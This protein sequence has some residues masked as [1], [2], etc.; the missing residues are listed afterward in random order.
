VSAPAGQRLARAYAWVVVAL[1]WPIIAGWLAALVAAVIFLP[2][3]GGPG[4]APLSDIVPSDAAAVRAQERALD[5]FGSTIAT[6]SL[7]VERDPA[8]LA[9]EDVEAQ[10]QAA[11]EQREPGLRAAVPVLNAPAPGVRWRERD[12]TLVTYLFISPDQNLLEREQT[13]Q[14]YLSGLPPGA[15]RGITGAGPARLAQWREIEDALPWTEA[16]TILTI[17]VIVAAYFRSAGA[18]L[19]TLATA[20]LAYVVAIRALAWIGERAGFTAPAEVEP[21]LVV[22]LIGLVTDYTIFFMAETRRRLRQGDSRLE[23]A[24][25]ATARVAPLVFA[26]GVLV[27]A[28]A[29]ALLAGEMRFFRVFG[30]GL[31]VAAVV[32]TLVCVTLVP[33][34]MGAL[35]PWLFGSRVRERQHANADPEVG[36]AAQRR[37]RG[38]VLTARPVAVLLVIACVGA[39]VVAAVGARTTSL[40]V[41]YV[42]SLPPD[43]EPRRAADDAAQ[44]FAPGILAPTELLLEQAG[45]AGRQAELERLQAL[46]ARQ[47]GVAAVIGAAQARGGAPP[48]VVVSEDGAA[49]RYALV[50]DDEPTGADAIATIRRL[51]RRMPALQRQAGLPT[52]VRTSYAGETALASE[53]VD[54]L[55][56]DLKRVV[57]ATAV[58]TFVLLALFLRAVIAPLLL[59]AGSV[60]AFAGSFGLTAVLLPHVL[61]TNDIIYYVPLVAAV[62]L[63]GL[64]SDYNVFI[65]GRIRDETRRRDLRDAIAAG[66][67][68]A[69]RTITVAGL[70]LAATFALL[71]IIPLRPFRELALLMT[72]GVLIDA[73][74]VRSVLVPALIAVA[75]RMSWWPSRPRHEPA[76]PSE[77]VG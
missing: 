17:L 76:V 34:V 27:A 29:L 30:P 45:I 47:P 9:R 71:A 11:A 68:S 14:T 5:A 10:L 55:V 60:L 7:I 69:S 54:A 66:A 24:R 8:G 46:L 38:R 39:L 37:P 4:S 16:A 74:L 2:G 63:V 77:Q 31:A 61:G 3:L 44:G 1:R 53:T 35:G 32:V 75:G 25:A 58:V 64:G 72:L 42:A 50:L 65:A 15:E 43:S 23:A 36:D 51:E 49:A 52:D 40:S 62:L 70:T 28:G 33:A 48:G 12:T 21:V 67:A 6:D 20:G 56:N 19:V 18:P 59:L 57:L 73:L 26:A 13:A 41:A 22:L